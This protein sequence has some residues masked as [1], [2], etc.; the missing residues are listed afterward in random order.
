MFSSKCTTYK[1]VTI[2]LIVTC[3]YLRIEMVEN[4][5]EIKVE[6][7]ESTASS[8]NNGASETKSDQNFNSST[9]VTQTGESNVET[10]SSNST[11]L[12]H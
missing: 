12:Q 1:M 6:N 2:V 3:I 10:S 4:T 5:D 7:S 9:K 11:I 8:I